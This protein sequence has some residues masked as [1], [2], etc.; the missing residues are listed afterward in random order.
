MARRIG[1]RETA[2]EGGDRM[3]KDY[4]RANYLRNEIE[5]AHRNANAADTMSRYAEASWWESREKEL[6][7]E[8]KAVEEDRGCE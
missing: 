1:G 7:E 4:K 3:S 5:I 2:E 8:L 6:W